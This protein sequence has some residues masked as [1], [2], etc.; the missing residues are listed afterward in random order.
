MSYNDEDHRRSILLIFCFQFV[1]DSEYIHPIILILILMMISI[2]ITKLRYTQM[3]WNKVRTSMRI[4]L[5][6]MHWIKWFR[7]IYTK[8]VSIHRHFHSKIKNIHSLFWI[9]IWTDMIEWKR[10]LPKAII[11]IISSFGN[12]RSCCLNIGIKNRRRIQS[13]LNHNKWPNLFSK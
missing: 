5:N 8:L 4:F 13:Y 9:I 12:Y 6:P 1:H 2:I 7:K 10:V 3:K 11:I